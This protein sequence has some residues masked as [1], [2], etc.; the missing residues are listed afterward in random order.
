MPSGPE[1]SIDESTARL[2]FQEPL[3]LVDQNGRM[4]EH[5]SSDSQLRV[6]VVGEL[7]TL[8]AVNEL[9]MIPNFQII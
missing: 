2:W 6:V 5:A 9:L 1:C 8:H 4:S 3:Y 7:L